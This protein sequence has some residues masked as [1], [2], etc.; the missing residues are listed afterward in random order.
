VVTFALLISMTLS[1]AF[2]V[3][4]HSACK[5]VPGWQRAAEQSP[6]PVPYSEPLWNVAVQLR[7]SNWS[8]NDRIVSEAEFMRF[9]RITSEMDPAPLNIVAFSPKLPCDQKRALQARI[10]DAAACPNAGKHCL[11]GTETEYRAARGLH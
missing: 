6:S 9:L 4:A 7:D 1:D 11:E 10:A 2:S 8:W 5:Q 3:A